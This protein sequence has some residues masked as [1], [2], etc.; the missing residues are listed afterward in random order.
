[1][2]QA[3]SPE[4]CLPEVDTK[5]PKR[6]AEPVGR[7]GCADAAARSR[8]SQNPTRNCYPLHTLYTKPTHHNRRQRALLGMHVPQSLQGATDQ[9]AGLLLQGPVPKAF[10][11][12]ASA[13]FSVAG[14][15]E[16]GKSWRGL[17]VSMHWV[18]CVQPIFLSDSNT[19]T[20]IITTHPHTF[21]LP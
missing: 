17:S 16:K 18:F 12:R 19:H 1:M 15:T 7:C 11:G 21:C 20:T 2:E 13:F 10:K 5:L 14:L 8:T 6:A 4:G 3:A 9:Q